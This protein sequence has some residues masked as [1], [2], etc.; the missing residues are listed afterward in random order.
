MYDSIVVEETKCPVCHKYVDLKF[1]TK[2][3]ERCLMV[4]HE[5][6]L[7]NY[8]IPSFGDDSK[9]RDMEMFKEINA[10]LTMTCCQCPKCKAFLHADF[11]I[12]NS[13]ILG[14]LKISDE[15][16]T[17]SSELVSCTTYFLNW[18]PTK[19]RKYRYKI[20]KDGKSEKI[21]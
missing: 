6:E 10:V 12:Y 11:L 3:F 19:E 7:L 9:Y 1:A 5:G 15:E 14:C 2:A 4:W 17:W 8:K 20:D 21:K 16:E 18:E 13:Q